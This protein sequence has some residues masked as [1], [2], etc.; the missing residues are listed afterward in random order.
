MKKGV[1]PVIA[2]VLLIAMVVVIGLIIF[3]WFSGIMGEAVLKFDKNIKLVCDDVKFDASYSEGDL[4]ISNVGNVPIYNMKA[5]ISEDGSHTT[6]DLDGWPG[7]GL[8]AGGAFEGFI[9]EDAD[10]IVLIPVLLGKTSKGEEKSYVC[11]ERQH[12]YEI[13]LS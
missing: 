1:S 3:L 5:K 10:K 11:N 2:T 7:T 9:T 13:V 4:Y 8:N 12:G 6:E